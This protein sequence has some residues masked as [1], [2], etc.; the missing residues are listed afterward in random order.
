M[1]PVWQEMTEIRGP[2]LSKASGRSF[3]SSSLTL[4][5]DRAWQIRCNSRRTFPQNQLCS[6][7]E[8]EIKQRD[9]RYIIFPR[10]YK[11]LFRLSDDR[12][13]EFCSKYV[14]LW[15]GNL[16]LPSLNSLAIALHRTLAD[17]DGCL[18]CS[19]LRWCGKLLVGQ[20][21]P[22][23]FLLRADLPPVEIWLDS[24]LF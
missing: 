3:V 17:A 11:N 1:Q 22:P 21:Q 4:G 2:S 24:S 5:T 15:K 19:Y 12:W 7:S 13:D 14:S 23:R 18:P 16:E 6:R 10:H 20:W 9:Q 8:G